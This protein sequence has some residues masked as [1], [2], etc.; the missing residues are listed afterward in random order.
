MRKTD[1]NRV[2]FFSKDDMAGG[3]QLKKGENI[4]KS[5]LRS[6]YEDINDILEL[7][8]I[9]QYF[10]NE[11]FLPG[12]TQDEITNFTQ[13][14]KKFGAVIAKFMSKI[15]DSNISSLYDNII[16]NYKDSFWDIINSQTVYKQI[17]RTCFSTILSRDSNIINTIL[18][19]RKIVEHYNTELKTF[20]LQYPKTAEIIISIYE[21][22]DDFEKKEKF[23]PKSLTI[24]DKENILSQYLDCED[25]NLNYINLIQNA[26]NSSELRVSDKTRL[27]ANRLHKKQTNEFFAE[28]QGLKIGVSV[29]FPENSEKIID[30]YIDNLTAHY[31]YSLDFIKKHNDPYS[32]FKN[33]EY[34]FGYIDE[35]KRIELVS[36][37]SQIGTFER[38]M[39]LNSRNYY[40]DGQSFYLSEMTS[41]CQIQAYVAVLNKLGHSIEDILHK[42]YTKEFKNKYSYAANARFHFPSSTNSFFERVRLLA[43]EFESVLKQ[44]KLFVEDGSIDFELLQISSTPSTIKD[45]PSLNENKYIYFNNQN[46]ELVSCCNLFFSDQS[47]LAYVKPYEDKQYGTLFDILTHEDVKFGNYEDFQKYRINYLIEKGLLSVDSKDYV[48]IANFERVLILRDLYENEV[49]SYYH[50]EANYQKEA[51]MMESENIIEFGTSL[52]SKPEQSY[53]NYFLNKSEYTNGL[54]LRNSY[55]HGTQADPEKENEHEYAYLIYL[56]LVVLAM[57][58]IDDDLCIFNALKKSRTV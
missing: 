44:Y 37:K 13:Q 41:Q 4:L 52:F 26:K 17:S 58:K 31:S 18:T 1:L 39:G 23:L 25:A 2:I 36:K 47:M 24:Q 35:Q 57:H 15:D 5:P 33:F 53:F 43:P 34:L 32:L 7:Y 49:A 46:S 54:D 50:Y 48:Q 20:L 56:K 14:T 45:I 9:K 11:I 8:H 30:G 12:W 10:D 21:V 3:M 27:K 22:K 19:K 55:V 28:R 51:L 29:S 42:V 16:F 6:D 38:F 40:N